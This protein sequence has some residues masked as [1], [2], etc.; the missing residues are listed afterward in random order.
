MAKPIEP[1]FGLIVS[2]TC[3]FDFYMSRREQK[4]GE[5]PPFLCFAPPTWLSW[6]N[7][8][9]HLIRLGLSFRDTQSSPFFWGG[10]GSEFLRNLGIYRS[11]GQKY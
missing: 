3:R 2:I 9:S 1:N 11:L 10:G 6:H 8:H 5:S 7:V 4:G